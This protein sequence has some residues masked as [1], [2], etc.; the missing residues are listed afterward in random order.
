MRIYTRTGDDG[1]TGLFGG[2][3][4]SK[5]ALRVETYGTV[6]E[7]NAVIGRARVSLRG[8]H[9]RALEPILERIQEELFT[10][11]AELATA[12]EKTAA[13]QKSMPLLEAS[14]AERLEREIDAAE[15]GVEPLK[16]F[17]LPG[18]TM[19]AA[20][21]HVARC[22]A[23]RAERLVVALSEQE[24]VRREL[25]VYLNRLSDLLFTL[26]RRANSLAGV[27]DVPWR[28]RA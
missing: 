19:A 1:T 23:R 9:A 13:L 17:V 16:F 4:L 21:L 14:A 7:A 11:G 20:D 3:R 6:D 24:P 25:L 12:P 22:V 18:G 8:G 5:H 27:A 15:Q 26:A 10:L 28:P 2:T